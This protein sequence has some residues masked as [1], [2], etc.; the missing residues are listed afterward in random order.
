MSLHQFSV[1]AIATVQNSRVDPAETDNWGKTTSRIVLEPEFDES[2]L[3]G[4]DEFSHVEVLFVFDR[5]VERDRYEP[6]PPRGR[7]DLPAVGVFAD[8]GPHRPNRIGA[9]FCRL[10]RVRGDQLVVAGLD[11]ADGTPVLDIKPA[12]A[13][14]LP[15]NVREPSWVGRLLR[16][17]Y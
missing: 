2:A 13:P 12:M 1:R 7:A 17:Y 16:E 5:A 10:V 14:F 9:S 8:R 4:L 11:A 15:R 3:L 6:R